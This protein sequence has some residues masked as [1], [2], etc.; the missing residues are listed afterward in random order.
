MPFKSVSTPYLCR[1]FREGYG[2][3]K[4]EIFVGIGF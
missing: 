2:L 3:K 4:L 1:K